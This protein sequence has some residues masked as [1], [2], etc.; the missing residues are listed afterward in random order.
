[1]ESNL[2]I[3]TVAAQGRSSRTAFPINRKLC[4]TASPLPIIRLPCKKALSARGPHRAPQTPSF[5]YCRSRVGRCYAT[6]PFSGYAGRTGP[7]W[8]VSRL[9]VLNRLAGLWGGCNRH[10][11]GHR[12][13][14]PGSSSQRLTGSQRPMGPHWLGCR[15]ARGVLR[16]F[17]PSLALLAAGALHR[18]CQGPGAAARRRGWCPTDIWRSPLSLAAAAVIAHHREDAWLDFQWGQIDRLCKSRVGRPKAR[19]LRR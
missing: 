13:R 9:F 15:A 3:A 12:P 1:M 11:S 10:D 17:R 6:C 5:S 19:R 18:M 8:I 7:R 2:K 4:A 16:R 14:A